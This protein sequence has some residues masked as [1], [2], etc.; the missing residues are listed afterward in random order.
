MLANITS[1]KFALCAQGTVLLDHNSG[2]GADDTG[3]LKELMPDQ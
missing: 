3:R 1:S 2:K